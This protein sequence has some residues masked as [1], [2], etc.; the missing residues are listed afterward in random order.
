MTV[1][2]RVHSFHVFAK[3]FIRSSCKGSIAVWALENFKTLASHRDPKSWH[4]GYGF[5]AGMGGGEII[6]L[7]VTIILI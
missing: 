2:C 5:D 4:P 6:L 7:V 1:P 3:R